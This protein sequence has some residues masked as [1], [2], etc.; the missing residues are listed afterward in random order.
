MKLTGLKDISRE[1]IQQI[2]KER[3]AELATLKAEKESSWNA[4]EEYLQST[5]RRAHDDTLWKA[6][7]KASTAY[8]NT[9]YE[10]EFFQRHLEPK[11]YANQKFYTD[12][13][14]WEV[15]E[16]HF[17]YLVI[18]KMSGESEEN[19]K[20]LPDYPTE[21]VKLHSNL[22]YY[23]P[24]ESVHDPGCTFHLSTSP[25]YYYDLEF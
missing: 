19:F 14:P 15:I 12:W 11:L 5:G 24:G 20:S 23:F 9:R 1:R 25:H 22:I 2:I 6:Y 18:R 4:W 21:I 13:R 16:D 17:T 7:D 10:L 8:E 3:S